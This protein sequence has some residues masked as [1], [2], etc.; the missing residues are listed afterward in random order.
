M[1]I[2]AEFYHKGVMTGELIPACG[3]RSVVIIDG[4]VTTDTQHD[5]ARTTCKTN[6]FL[7]YR[8]MRGERFTTAT[9]TTDIIPVN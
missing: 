9:P 2:H 8:L 6:G 7:A 5:I 4:R 1:I 3:D